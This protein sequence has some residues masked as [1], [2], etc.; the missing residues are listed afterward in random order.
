MTVPE[1]HAEPVT[2]LEQSLMYTEFGWGAWPPDE[3]DASELGAWRAEHARELA[4]GPEELRAELAES[5]AL[6]KSDAEPEAE[7][8][9]GDIDE[10]PSA[11]A[12]EWLAVAPEDRHPD[13]FEP[14]VDPASISEQALYADLGLPEPEPEAEL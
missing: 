3:R 2:E 12:A 6:L 10:C 8:W 5:E 9:A 1:P 13:G 4:L 11:T 14:R 7:A